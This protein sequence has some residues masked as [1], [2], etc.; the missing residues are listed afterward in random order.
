MNL[1]LVFVFGKEGMEF[2]IVLVIG[3]LILG[4]FIGC[5]FLK[6][7]CNIFYFIS[8]GIVICGGSVIVVVGF[9]VKVNDSEMFVVLVIIFILNV[10][11][12]FIFL[13]IGYVL[14]MS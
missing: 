11:V 2:M 9:V 6:V 5:K 3:I 14:N 1:Y 8:L 4:W 10:F 12:F 7:D 13:V